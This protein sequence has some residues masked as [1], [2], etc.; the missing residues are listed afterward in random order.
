MSQVGWPEGYI[1]PAMEHLD[2]D[3]IPIEK[4]RVKPWYP[5]H[6]PDT[7]MTSTSTVR[8]SRDN[9]FPRFDMF[10]KDYPNLGGFIGD[11]DVIPGKKDGGVRQARK[12][13]AKRLDLEMTGPEVIYVA[14][15]YGGSRG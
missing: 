6:F 10:Y 3:N 13:Q 7:G 2:S 4:H 1:E 12:V 11:S 15:R 8:Q 14:P 5:T 9:L